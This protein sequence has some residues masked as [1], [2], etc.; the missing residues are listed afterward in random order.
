MSAVTAVPLRPLARGSVLKLWIGLALLAAVAAGLAWWSTRW[1][2]VTI[3]DSGARYRA[4]V[5]GSGPAFTSEDAVALHLRL[6][7][8]SVGAR[9]LADTTADEDGP[10]PFVATLNRLPP[11]LRG[12]AP[13]FRAGGRYLIWV[14]ARA[15]VGADVP[16]G[17]PFTNSDTLVLEV[18]VLQIAPGQASAL[19]AQRMQ[20]LVQR[21][22]MEQ[23]QREQAGNGAAPAAGPPAVNGAGP[24]GPR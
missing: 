14:P 22:M 23:L 9:P 7:V 21:Q 19:E 2:Q 18:Q 24:A 6:H 4:I 13:A 5:E 10:S 17:A 1:M 8:G 3:L 11:G 15:Y 20:Q 12:V 16:A